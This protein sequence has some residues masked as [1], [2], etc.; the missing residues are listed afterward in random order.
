MSFSFHVVKAFGLWV[1]SCL[2]LLFMWW[3][4]IWDLLLPLPLSP[5]FSWFCHWSGDRTP[6]P[7]DPTWKK[8]QRRNSGSPSFVTEPSL[9]LEGGLFPLLVY[10]P[11]NMGNTRVV[12]YLPLPSTEDWVKFHLEAH[13]PQ[14]RLSITQLFNV[15]CIH[16]HSHLPLTCVLILEKRLNFCLEIEYEY[17]NSLLKG[18]FKKIKKASPRT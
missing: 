9:E 10:Q 8:R 3:E 1:W 14:G 18:E 16:V 4:K 5:Q 13:S 15:S 11:W 17:K 2:I 7:A 12:N 6:I